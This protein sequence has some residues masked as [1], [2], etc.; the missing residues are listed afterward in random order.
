MRTSIK[1]FV[2][3]VLVSSTV[4]FGAELYQIS[5]ARL[6]SDFFSTT[7]GY[8]PYDF[9]MKYAFGSDVLDYNAAGKG[10]FRVIKHTPLTELSPSDIE[11]VCFTTGARQDPEDTY[12]I[13]ASFFLTKASQKK[14]LSALQSGH[15]SH[16]SFEYKN[17]TVTN[18]WINEASTQNYTKTRSRAVEPGYNPLNRYADFSFS[19]WALNDQDLIEVAHYFSPDKIP[20]GCDADFRPE[21]LD[22]WSA[23]LEKFWGRK[24]KD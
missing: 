4:F 17:F 5:D 9:A 23:S 8:R 6:S 2:F 10:S 11:L 19:A 7:S 1:G 20:G 18:F 24:A 16:V 13:S 14:F 21:K 12:E 22:V 15:Q 3:G